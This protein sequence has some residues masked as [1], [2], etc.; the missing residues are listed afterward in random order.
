[1]KLYEFWSLTEAARKDK[2]PP[3]E[4]LMGPPQPP[5]YRREAQIVSALDYPFEYGTTN[6]KVVAEI[7]PEEAH[8]FSPSAKRALENVVVFTIYKDKLAGNTD[9][10]DLIKMRKQY[11]FEKHGNYVQTMV[12]RGMGAML[13]AGGVQSLEDTGKPRTQI[14][15][16]YSKRDKADW[17]AMQDLVNSPARKIIVPMPSSSP[18]V[19]MM[20]K[21]FQ[22]S[23]TIKNVEVSDVLYKSDPFFSNTAAR[24]A[25]PSHVDGSVKVVGNVKEQIKQLQDDLQYYDKEEPEAIEISKKLDYL[26][27]WLKKQP[28]SHSAKSVYRSG[29]TNYGKWLYGW[30]KSNKLQDTSP[31]DI[32]LVDDNVTRGNTI[33]AATKAIVAE[34]PNVRSIRVIA[35]HHLY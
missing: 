29:H 3:S 27:K 34:N 15:M 24:M 14:N 10:Q 30:M 18:L 9:L 1:M 6:I 19:G 33:V 21:A 11:S 25:D 31:V 32:I 16:P 12:T 8:L 17:R 5:K 35:L 23:D 13:K 22:T 20:V 2:A 4:E 7:L 28:L 26:Q